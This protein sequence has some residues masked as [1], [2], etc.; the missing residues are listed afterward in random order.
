MTSKDTSSTVIDLSNNISIL[1]PV[2]GTSSIKKQI[3]QISLNIPR[4]KKEKK[5]N[6][7]KNDNLTVRS[8]GKDKSMRNDMRSCSSKNSVKTNNSNLNHTSSSSIK[9]TNIKSIM[10]NLD[11]NS[12]QTHN[13]ND[14]KAVGSTKNKYSNKILDTNNISGKH[15]N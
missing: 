1:H 12:Y 13:P 5:N 4:E 15:L 14:S 3:K 11:S 9:N 2:A 6:Q 10:K 8:C 7:V